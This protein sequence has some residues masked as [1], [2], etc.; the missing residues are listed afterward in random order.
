MSYQI[1]PIATLHSCFKEKFG[2]P[3]QAGLAPAARAWI[4]F[5]AP[6]CRPEAFYGLQDYSHVWLIFVFHHS[7]RNE[8]GLTVQPPRREGERYGLFATRSPNRPN[9]IGQSVVAIERIEEIAGRV[10]L[11]VLGADLVDGTPILDVKPYVPYVDAIPDAQGGFAHTP[12]KIRLSVSWS[13]QAE[14][15]LAQYRGKYPGLAELV[16]QVLGYDPRSLYHRKSSAKRCY[17]V[18]LYDLNV[19]FEVVADEQVEVTRIMFVG[20]EESTTLAGV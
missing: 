15:D 3:S 14:L 12:P 11:H 17:G 6:Y 10:R 19:L 16:E 1:Q 13:A 2:I 20:E 7:L 4:E 18:S 5:E 8:I 9:Q